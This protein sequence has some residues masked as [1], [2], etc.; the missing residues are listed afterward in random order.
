M[1]NILDAIRKAESDRLDDAVPSLEA[2]VEKK[3][4]GKN[5]RGSKRIGGLIWVAL[6]LVVAGTVYLYKDPLRDRG[7]VLKHRIVDKSRVLFKR[8]GVESLF[9]Q[10]YPARTVLSKGEGTIP[11]PSGVDARSSGLNDRQA[12]LLN[13]LRFDVVSFSKDKVKR[14]AMV[15]SQ[16]YREGDQLE[17]FL[18]KQISTEG[19]ILDVNGKNIL[20]RP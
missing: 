4:V 14:F 16:T 1:S 12:Q 20:V 13:A 18:V 8:I 9:G 3:R 15:G 2:I 10:S 17:G 7:L 19:V 6:A 11:Q 5:K